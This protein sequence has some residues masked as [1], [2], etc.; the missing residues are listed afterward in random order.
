MNPQKHTESDIDPGIHAWE[1][2]IQSDRDGVESNCDE[3][4]DESQ[5]YKRSQVKIGRYVANFSLMSTKI[6]YLT[7]STT[8]IMAEYQLLSI[9]KVERHQFY[10]SV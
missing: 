6:A 2:W 4:S 7:G 9:T 1:H 8:D 10:G 3:E 5:L